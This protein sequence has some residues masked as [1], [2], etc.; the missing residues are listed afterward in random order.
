MERR[1]S[2]MRDRRMLTEAWRIESR[3]FFLKS[4]SALLA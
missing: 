4:S 3:Q 1:I 2:F